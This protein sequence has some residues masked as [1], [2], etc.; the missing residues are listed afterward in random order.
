MSANVNATSTASFSAKAGRKCPS[1]A[2]LPA[3]ASRRAASCR[4]R[5]HRLKSLPGARP[6]RLGDHRTLLVQDHLA[7]RLDSITKYLVYWFDERPGTRVCD[8]I[9]HASTE[10][11]RDSFFLDAAAP[12]AA[13]AGT[14]SSPGSKTGHAGPT[15]GRWRK[16]GASPPACNGSGSDSATRSC[17]RCN[18]PELLRTWFGSTCGAGLSP[19]QHGVPRHAARTGRV[20][21]GA[22]VL[23]AHHALLGRL[24]HS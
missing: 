2:A 7:P 14:R 24:E 22:R 10:Q 23:V 8:V 9:A 11:D 20:R 1:T 6:D 18:G 3:P 17:A 16:R 4:S 21:L 13:A 5:R 12:G 15:R 19:R